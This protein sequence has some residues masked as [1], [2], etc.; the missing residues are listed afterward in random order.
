MLKIQFIIT[1]PRTPIESGVP[2]L[3]PRHL[4]PT[5]PP[6]QVLVAIGNKITIKKEL[7]RAFSGNRTEA[8][9][10]NTPFPEKMGI[11]IRPLINAT[12]WGS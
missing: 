7:S 3:V 6:S 4:T 8:T 12:E 10:K 2:M 9:P 5:P 1:P 11:R